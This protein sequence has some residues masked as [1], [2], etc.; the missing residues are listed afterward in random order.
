MIDTR[1]VVGL[2][3]VLIGMFVLAI[4]G[5]QEQDRMAL[6]AES[7]KALS[8]QRG[9]LIFEQNCSTCHGQNGQGVLGRGPALNTD[10]FFND[11]LKEVGYQGTLESYVTLTVAGGRPVKSD[12]QYAQPMPTW[13]QEYGG[14]L[15]EDEIND[16][17]AFVMNWAGEERQPVEAV[18]E[19]C[20]ADDEACLGRVLFV[21]TVGCGACHAVAGYS[22]G[23]VGPDL[24]NTY[25]EKGADYIRESILM[26]NAVITPGFAPGIMPQTFG[27]LLT[28]EQLD[29][30]IAFLESVSAQ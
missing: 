2:I 24:T 27:E 9:A 25:A 18:A 26:P 8:I 7:Q 22:S 12:P 4:I 19:E 14:P 30:I 15:R 13:S 11:R 21:Q 3:V 10:F 20:A 16:V 23:A 1:I 17:V 29:N 28:D 5:I 6:A